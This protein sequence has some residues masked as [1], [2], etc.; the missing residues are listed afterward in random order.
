MV[1]TGDFAPNSLGD[2]HAYA[3]PIEGVE[4]SFVYDKNNVRFI[5]VSNLRYLAKRLNLQGDKVELTDEEAAQKIEEFITREFTKKEKP[6]FLY[7]ESAQSG[8][9]VR[10]ASIS[11]CKVIIEQH[12]YLPAIPI[13][14]DPELFMILVP[15]D[16]A[17]GLASYIRTEY[18]AQF[19]KVRNRLPLHLNIV[20]F[21][22]KQPIYV[23]LDAAHRML[24]RKSRHDELW[25]VQSI[26]EADAKELCAHSNG[27]LTSYC[28][29]ITLKRLDN[30]L[31]K[32]CNIFVSYGLGD[33]SKM[34]T[35]HPYFFAETEASGEQVFSQRDHYFSAPLPDRDAYKMKDLVHVIDL[36]A[37]DQVYYTPSTLDFEFL[38]VTAKRFELAYDEESNMRLPKA[39][40]TY[41]TRPFLLED[42]DIIQR[43][44]ELVAKDR[45]T[46]LTNTQLKQIT[47]M[48]E[49]KRQDW[50]VAEPDNDTLRRFAEQTFQ[51]SSGRKWNN[52]SAIDKEHLISWATSGRWRDLIELEMQI[53]KR[54]SKATK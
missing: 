49:T 47:E 14:T 42:L 25:E 31:N 7:E 22:R 41:S 29:C 23:A 12:N 40:E 39:H 8:K 21:N 13:I 52:V 53:L 3:V 38:D 1:I 51:R 24:D 18:E 15:A 44:W 46:A 48:I 19:S 10:A 28:K 37:G 34:D 17:L 36:K 5:S 43:L 26:S 16:R 45:S 4:A 32:T 35:W 9:Q 30:R 11:Q 33:P 50:Q 54:K 27:R 6:L 2:Y 20:F